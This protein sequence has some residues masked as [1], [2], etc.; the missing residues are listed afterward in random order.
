M[1][2]YHRLEI[3]KICIPSWLAQGVPLLCQHRQ[4]PRPCSAWPP[5]PR[6]ASSHLVRAQISQSTQ[7][8]IQ[9]KSTKHI[10]VEVYSIAQCSSI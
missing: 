2:D 5:A 1:L 4:R 8:Y 6:A 7:F 10:S 9:G 3:T